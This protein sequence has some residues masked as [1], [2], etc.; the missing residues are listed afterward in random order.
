METPA[1]TKAEALRIWCNA[2]CQTGPPGLTAELK[3]RGPEDP[4]PGA[5]L[6]LKWDNAELDIF[7]WEIGHIEMDFAR[8]LDSSTPVEVVYRFLPDVAEAMEFID[9]FVRARLD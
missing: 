5:S 4:A 1:A 7:M 3:T 2:I 6:M 9:A 8:M